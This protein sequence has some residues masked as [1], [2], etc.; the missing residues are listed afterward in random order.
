MD[1]PSWDLVIQQSTAV[2]VTFSA[3][4]QGRCLTTCLVLQASCLWPDHL[5]AL[6]L[7]R[8]A[9]AMFIHCLTAQ[10]ASDCVR[11]SQY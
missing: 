8:S 3:L 11:E 10:H 1:L 6:L 7:A 9:K 5:L 2:S 4:V